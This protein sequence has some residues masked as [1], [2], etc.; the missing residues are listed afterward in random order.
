[1]LDVVLLLFSSVQLSLVFHNE[2]LSQALRMHGS[3]VRA[4]WYRLFW[5]LLVAAAHFF[6]LEWLK[7][8]LA[9]GFP[10]NSFPERLATFASLELKAFLSAWFLAAWVCLYCACMKT[11]PE[12]TF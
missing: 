6:L 10:E 9:A 7:N 1:L 4:H 3:F 12:A 5:F 11:A 8:Y 2:T